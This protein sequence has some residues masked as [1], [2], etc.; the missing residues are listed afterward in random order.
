MILLW[1]LNL[2]LHIWCCTVF[3]GLFLFFKFA[4]ALKCLCTQRG[5][6]NQTEKWRRSIKRESTCRHNLISLHSAPLS[7]SVFHLI[8]YCSA[9]WIC[10][11]NC[12][13]EIYIKTLHSTP[14]FL[15]CLC[16]PHVSD[17]GEANL[18]LLVVNIP[19]IRQLGGC[20]L[21]DWLTARPVPTGQAMEASY[22][23]TYLPHK[24]WKA[25]NEVS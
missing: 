20:S 6:L 16:F 8:L 21:T 14:G 12:A 19:N 25:T 24:S 1:F 3:I 4:E 5:A 18:A 11:C 2:V 10:S 22:A 17:R 23:W 15:M 9:L 7:A 13:E